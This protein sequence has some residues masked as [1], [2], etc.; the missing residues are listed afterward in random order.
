[1]YGRF[2]LPCFSLNSAFGD[3]AGRANSCTSAAADA[4]ISVDLKLSVAH[5]D[6][7]DRALSLTCSACYAGVT[8]NKCHNTPP[9][10]DFT[11]G[12]PNRL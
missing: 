2:V 8:D 9:V 12:N 4:L 11:T 1:M 10:R 7:A 6:S 3:S 5:G